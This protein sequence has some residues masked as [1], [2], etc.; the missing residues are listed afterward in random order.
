MD[1]IDAAK[2]TILLIT[3]KDLLIISCIFFVYYRIRKLDLKV[4]LL[5]VAHRE[6]AMRLGNPKGGPELGQP[7]M[8]ESDPERWRKSCEDLVPKKKE[9]H[10]S[11]PGMSGMATS[12]VVPGPIRT[13]EKDV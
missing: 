12:D 13:E 6:S 10:W 7:H 11:D 9:T 5:L 3:I 1:P 8:S 4:D 2:L